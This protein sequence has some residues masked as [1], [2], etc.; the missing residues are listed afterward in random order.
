MVF[1]LS[2]RHVDSNE[3]RRC[4]SSHRFTDEKAQGEGKVEP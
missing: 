1:V 3:L 2:V 4:N